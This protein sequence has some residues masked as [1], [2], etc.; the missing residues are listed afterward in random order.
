MTPRSGPSARGRQRRFGSTAR[1]MVWKDADITGGIVV[2]H[3]GS[4]CGRHRRARGRRPRPPPRRDAARGAGLAPH[5]R[6]ATGLDGRRLRPALRRV[7]AGRHR[8]PEGRLRRCRAP[9]RPRPRALRPPR[10]VG[11]S[12]WSRP[13]GRPRCSSSAYGA[14]AGSPDCRLGST[15]TQVVRHS[16]VP[17][18][19]VPNIPDSTPEVP[20][21]WVRD[22]ARAR[23]VQLSRTHGVGA[24]RC[25]V[26]AG[27][28]RRGR[29][30]PLL[31]HHPERGTG[32]RDRRLPVPLEGRPR[33]RAR[34]A[35]W[36]DAGGRAVRGPLA[37]WRPA[38]LVVAREPGRGGGGR[39]TRAPLAERF[40]H[41]VRPGRQRGAGGRCVPA[42]RERGVR[43]AGA[44]GWPAAPAWSSYPPGSGGPTTPCARRSR[45][46][47]VPVRCWPGW[48]RRSATTSPRGRDG[49]G[50]LPGRRLTCGPRSMR[51]WAR[52]GRVDFLAD[53]EI[54]AQHDVE[55]G[56]CR[57]SWASRSGRRRPRAAHA[58]GAPGGFLTPRRSGRGHQTSLV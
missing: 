13:G 44:R 56:R 43:M 46:C 5:E 32:A 28:L 20:I 1:G 4:R 27:R 15:A 39:A 34:R 57:C 45:T 42:Q 31:H 3:D 50:G 18:L 36:R 10:S 41:R 23:P 48:P 6:P 55:R 2:G 29:R 53:V 54:A 26:G 16:A 40:H 12:A 37:R 51:Q 14:P 58:R 35:S 33:R 8:G 25:G 49:G 7:R 21:E 24:D 19:V 22:A 9:R 17:V 52:A 47:G 30:R 38:G 11:R